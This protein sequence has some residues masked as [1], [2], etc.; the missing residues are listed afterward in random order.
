MKEE[1]QKSDGNKLAVQ[2]ESRK[3][4]RSGLPPAPMSFCFLLPFLL[5]S[6]SMVY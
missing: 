1:D 4:L 5:I 6:N 3:G 2:T